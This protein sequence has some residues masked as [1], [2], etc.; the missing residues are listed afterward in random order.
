MLKQ[1]VVSKSLAMLVGF[2]FVLMT[3]M[4]VASYFF[5][6]GF[7]DNPPLQS[8]FTRHLAISAA[9]ALLAVISIRLLW[10]AQFK[11]FEERQEKILQFQQDVMDRQVELLSSNGATC[12]LDSSGKVVAA[13]EGLFDMLGIPSSDLVGQTLEDVVPCFKQERLRKALS[14]AHESGKFWSGEVSGYPTPDRGH[15]IAEMTVI[16]Q[17]D[18]SGENHQVLLVLSDKT[19]DRISETNQFLGLML[20]ELQ[21]EIYVYEAESLGIRYLNQSARERCGW[22]VD[23]ARKRK[24]SETIPHFN[25]D[26]FRKHVGP[27]LAN[28][29]DSATIEIRSADDVVEVVTRKMTG[30]DGANLF[31]SSLR[32]LSHR[33]EI[34]A[35]K[36]QTVSMVSHELR[37]PLAS[38]KGSLSLLK[39]GS[40][41]EL[42]PSVSKVVE[43]ADRNSERLLLI[44]NDILDL[45]K[46]RSGKMDFSTTPIGLG[47]L[48][49]EAIEAN[50]PYADRHGVDLRL[51]DVPEN[52]TVAVNQDR[53]MQ[54]LTNLLSNA[55]KFSDTGDTVLLG[56]ENEGDGW[57]ISVS[58]NGPGMH[59][60][61]IAEIGKPFNQHKPLDGKKREGTGLGL[62]I[63]KQILGYHGTKLAVESTKGAGS[64]F[65]FALKSS[66]AAGETVNLKKFGGAAGESPRTLHS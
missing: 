58:D 26:L 57:R 34:E 44:V 18:K 15:V 36:M 17:I 14:D 13:S 29:Q 38:I 52:A 2:L 25:I 33:N 19:Q 61:A 55:I 8:F 11:R 54:V 1:C 9:V 43:I 20:E 40:L 27:L 23:T 49:A 51:S 46:I 24:I 10:N 41:G 7:A 53:I 39:S 59:E 60:Q 65:S 35:A 63:V 66:G 21:E 37:S 64:T 5:A 62:T 56:V 30:L 31:V 16:P 45:E 4:A 22:S 48:L 47:A 6:P 32:D 42:S 50:Q 28:E 3:G 12:I